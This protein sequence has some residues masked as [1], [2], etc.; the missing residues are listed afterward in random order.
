MSVGSSNLTDR[1]KFPSVCVYGRER[2][3]SGAFICVSSKEVE[4]ELRSLEGRS[5]CT[6]KFRRAR[7]HE[8]IRNAHFV[9]RKV[10][11]KRSLVI[12]ASYISL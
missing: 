2:G 1:F 9:V 6:R 3:S 5:A 8:C 12:P 11:E 4:L 10:H 7:V